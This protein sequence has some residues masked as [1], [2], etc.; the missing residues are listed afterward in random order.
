MRKEVAEDVHIQARVCTHTY[1][2]IR[3]VTYI[4]RT[5]FL[6]YNISYYYNNY[7]LQKKQGLKNKIGFETKGTPQNHII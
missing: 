1:A 2:C 7:L 3:R 6:R 5:N 4:Q